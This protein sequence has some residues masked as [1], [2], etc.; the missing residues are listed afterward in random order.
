MVWNT[1]SIFPSMLMHF[2]NNG[3]I[4][5]LVASPALQ[6]YVIGPDGEPRWIAVAARAGAPR[7][8]LRLLPPRAARRRGSRATA[9][10]AA[11]AHTR[12]DEGHPW[13]QPSC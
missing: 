3:A 10:P 12:S 8:G 2:I 13:S 7:S 1:R 5:V 11:R 9:E 4:L 6:A